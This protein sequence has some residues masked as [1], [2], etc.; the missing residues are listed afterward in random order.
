MRKLIAIVVAAAVVAAAGIAIGLSSFSTKPP[1]EDIPIEPS[2]EIPSDPVAPDATPQS[3]DDIN[4]LENIPGYFGLVNLGYSDEMARYLSSVK[5]EVIS[6]NDTYYH[7][8]QTTLDGTKSES[9]LSL[10]PVQQFNA[11]ESDKVK[12]AQGFDVYV[13]HAKVDELEGGYHILLAYVIP[14]ESMPSDLKEQLSIQPIYDL[15]PF[16]VQHA[17]AAGTQI[18]G[19]GVEISLDRT[20][21]SPPRITAAPMEPVSTLT[22][23]GFRELTAERIRE[24]QQMIIDRDRVSE[25][26]RRAA[27]AGEVYTDPIRITGTD[28]WAQQRIAAER[29]VLEQVRDRAIRDATVDTLSRTSGRV[30]A[31][32]GTAEM[33]IGVI[34]DH[35][36]DSDILNTARDCWESPTNRVTQ[37]GQRDFPE[38]YA[39]LGEQLDTAGEELAVNTGARVLN[40]GA[41]AAAGAS[42]G[43]IGS[44]GTGG[45]TMANDAILSNVQR[46]IMRDATRGITPC[47]P[48][49]EDSENQA[50]DSTEFTP[51]QYADYTPGP[52]EAGFY[53]TPGPR[54][55]YEEPDSQQCKPPEPNTLRVV[56]HNSVQA[57]VEQ[58]RQITFQASANLTNRVPVAGTGL[59]YEVVDFYGNGTGFYHETQG[60]RD[61]DMCF[62]EIQGLATMEVKVLRYMSGFGEEYDLAEVQVTIEGDL[63]IFMSPAGCYVHNG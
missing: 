4:S 41:D 37:E 58:S 32:L 54:N 17:S 57:G 14:E 33:G 24:V 47:T 44:M 62:V 63:P 16:N 3:R 5:L 12:V 26:F 10:K 39:R 1:T 60:S 45:I 6:S 50:T 59:T 21:V 11:T 34:E 27:E 13:K 7:Y 29:Q 55:W 42:T 53:Y 22:T 38:D 18:Y 35:L 48:C 31:G 9:T 36:R 15:W 40:V 28:S 30:L 2:P 61:P 49:P 43:F 20:V 46:D 23:P 19:I 51:I 52:D 8:V 56:I 25:A